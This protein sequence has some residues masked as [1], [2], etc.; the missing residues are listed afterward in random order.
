MIWR[1]HFENS[2][3]RIESSASETQLGEYPDFYTWEKSMFRVTFKNIASYSEIKVNETKYKAY[4]TNEQIIIEMTDFMRYLGDGAGGVIDFKTI[5]DDTI[6]EFDFVIHYGERPSSIATERLPQEIP[7]NHE[8]QIPFYY[9]TTEA[10][11]EFI[12][13]EWVTVS[14]GIN[15]RLADELQQKV[16]RTTDEKIY[17]RFI[18]LPCWTDKVL[19]QWVGHFGKR[20]SWWFQ[21]ERSVIGSDKQLSLQTLDNGFNV[22][23][24]KRNS[25][26]VVH[27]KSD[28]TTQRYLSDLCLS[29]EVYIFI[30]DLPNQVKVETNSV[31]IT[32]KKRDIQ[33]LINVFAYDTI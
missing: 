5:S 3:F 19:V 1:S 6:Y 22:I 10:M 26:Q 25:V 27:K 20:K 30:D 21:V 33:F 29:D 18:D 13:G 24:N 23:K 31:D 16:I 17:T 28:Q 12:G 15:E 32:S 11:D 8:S 14:H 2:N 4:I 7:F 9:Q